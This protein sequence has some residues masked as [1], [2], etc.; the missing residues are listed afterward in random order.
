[1]SGRASIEDKVEGDGPN[2][3]KDDDRCKQ[4]ALCD[5]RP[6]AFFAALHGVLMLSPHIPSSC[7]GPRDATYIALV[8]VVTVPCGTA[9]SIARR[10]RG[11]RSSGAVISEAFPD[12]DEV[13]VVLD[14]TDVLSGGD[15]TDIDDAVVASGVIGRDGDGERE[16]RDKL[17]ERDADCEDRGVSSETCFMNGHFGRRAAFGSFFKSRWAHDRVSGIPRP[18]FAVSQQLTNSILLL[19]EMKGTSTRPGQVRRSLMA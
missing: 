3:C 10:G 9:K 7:A 16:G 13:F 1:M 2:V 6:N 5:S 18:C 8:G 19:N 12:N 15:T 4:D 14:V 11:Q 17:D